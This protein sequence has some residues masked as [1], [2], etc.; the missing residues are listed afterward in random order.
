LFEEQVELQADAVA[1]EF[2][3]EQLSYEELNERANQLGWYLRGL[4]V[5]PEVRV[6]ICVERSVEMVVSVLG[7]LKAGGAYVPLEVSYPAERLRYMTADAGVAV[8]LTERKLAAQFEESSARVVCLDEEG[9]RIGEESTQNPAEQ[10]LP[11]HL[12]YVIYT[13]G[14]SGLPKG[15]AVQHGNL[16]NY[17]NWVNETFFVGRTS[18]LPFV[19]SLSFDAS[20][21]QILGPLIRGDRVWVVASDTVSEPSVLVA[22]LNR[23]SHVAL[24]CVPSLWAACLTCQIR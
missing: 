2:G 7:I 6:G 5:G 24:N 19:T 15:V 22:E 4:G 13:S 20:L 11:E 18:S 3:G 16:T 10:S 21:K 9:A 14:S 17:L 12:A 23:R 8:L 1:V